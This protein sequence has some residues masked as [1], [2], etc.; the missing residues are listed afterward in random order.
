[1]RIL[2]F[3]KT[4]AIGHTYLTA[5][6]SLVIIGASGYVYISHTSNLTTSVKQAPQYQTVTGKHITQEITPVATNNQPVASTLSTPTTYTPPTLSTPTT[7]T[8]PTL[9]TPTTYTPPTP[10]A[11]VSTPATPSC[12]TIVEA[13]DVTAFQNAYNTDIGSAYSAIEAYGYSPPF[14]T[15]IEP[16]ILAI[17]D[18]FNTQ[19]TNLK[20]SFFNEM[21]LINCTMPVPSETGL[22]FNIN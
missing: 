18:N 1:M 7:Y 6:A 11:T 19:W 13:Q 16:Q 12:N 5:L 15:S 20:I 17:E 9:S 4:A 10:T 22:T 8:P 21:Q 14:P 2:Y 3:I